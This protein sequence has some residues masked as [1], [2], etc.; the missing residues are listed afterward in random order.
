[1]RTAERE[2]TAPASGPDDDAGWRAVAPAGRW[3]S[4]PQPAAL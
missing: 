2:L 1:L 4:W 3:G